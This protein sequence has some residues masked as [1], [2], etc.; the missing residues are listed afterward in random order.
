MPILSFETMPST[1]EDHRPIQEGDQLVLCA[2][3]GPTFIKKGTS[4]AIRTGVKLRIPA[5]YTCAVAFRR[6]H[7]NGSILTDLTVYTP[8]Q[9]LDADGKP[10]E[11]SEGE[12]LTAEI[13]VQVAAP[14][15]S[16]LNIRFGEPFAVVYLSQFVKLDPPKKLEES[17]KLKK[18]E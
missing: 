18:A 10:V 16:D 3:E 9:K 17:K 12:G 11:G 2:T 5:G 4:K 6:K 13:S 1:H 8:S 14:T 15:N 7:G